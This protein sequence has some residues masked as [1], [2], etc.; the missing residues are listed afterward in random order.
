MSALLVGIRRNTRLAEVGQEDDALTK[1]DFL[2]P[3][4]EEC[5]RDAVGGHAAVV[6]WLLSVN[7]IYKLDRL[8]VWVP[9][10]LVGV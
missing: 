1:D 7:I 8:L 10:A 5:R 9:E 3:A 2:V 6:R 4:A